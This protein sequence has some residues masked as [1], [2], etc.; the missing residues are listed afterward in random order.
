MTATLSNESGRL[1]VI[2]T[3]HLKSQST[4]TEFIALLKEATGKAPEGCL[5]VQLHA[6]LD[7]TKVVNRSEWTDMQSF[8]RRFDGDAKK[9]FG[10]IMTMVERVEQEPYWLV[11]DI[12][13]ASGEQKE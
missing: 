1:F 13:L 4:P 11:A 9:A 8:E 5:S 3:F 7:G 12:A 10:K 2:N 6:S